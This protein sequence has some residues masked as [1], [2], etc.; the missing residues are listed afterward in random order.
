MEKLPSSAAAGSTTWETIKIDFLRTG[1]AGRALTL[2]SDLVD[3]TVLDAWR[4]YLAPKTASGLALLAVGGYG[5]RQLFPYS[6]VD[7]LLLFDSERALH[8]SKSLLA[9]FLQSLWD[10]GLRLSQSVRTIEECTELH[11]SNVELNVSLLDLRFLAGDAQFSGKLYERLP[12]FVHAQRQALVRNMARL[13]RERHAKYGDTFYHLEPNIKEAPGGLRD[14]QLLCWLTQIRGSDAKHI[15]PSAQPADL[16]AARR[17]FFHLRCHL[18]Y[19]Y[20]RD[21]NFL[22][23]D[24]QEWLAEIAGQTPE[25][26]MREYFLHARDFY[27]SAE[28]LLEETETQ[29]PSLFSNFRDWRSRLSNSEFAVHR[30]RVFFKSPQLLERDPTLALRLFEFAARH[31]LRLSPDTE[32]RLAAARGVLSYYYSKPHPIWLEF[33][34]LLSLPYAEV[35]L[36]EM[37]DTG[38]LTLLF[39]EFSG[40]ECLVVRDFYH[41]Y[42]VDE[43]TLVT[44]QSINDLRR[45]KESDPNFAARKPYAT[46][47]S[48][49]EEPALLLFALLFHDTGKAG[50][51]EHHS[52]ASLVLANQAMERIHVP[53]PDREAVRFLI[54]NHLDMS[55]TL[56]GRD[57]GDAAVVEAFAHRV[58]TVERLKALTLLTYADISGVNP[59]AMTPWRATQ[60]FSLY[61][62]TYHELTR[63]LDAER[64]SAR[65]QD[66]PQKAAFLSGFPTRYLRTHSEAEIEGHFTMSR[67]LA[68][69]GFATQMTRTGGGWRLTVLAKDRP[70]LFAS[71]AGTLSAFG[72]NILKAEAFANRGGDILDT[73]VFADPLRNL[74]LNPSEVDRLKIMLERVI[75]GWFD[76]RDLLRNRP[77]PTP[78]SRGAEVEPLV[79][80]DSEASNSATLIQ[81]TAADRPGLLYDLASRMSAAGCNIEVV[82]IDTEAHKAIDVFYVTS[83]QAKLTPRLQDKLREDLL[84]VCRGH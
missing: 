84:G 78:P 2:R 30:E 39:P 72:L 22:T 59:S 53:E 56:H 54:A 33:R 31:S 42:T 45:L 67:R 18:H 20:D 68:E 1:D 62:I 32:Q 82:L 64:I 63:E 43:H 35:A 34:N 26:W 38:F 13:T 15:A 47:L 21:S 28:R 55:A 23:F 9:P 25:K 83:G 10:S 4:E 36:R 73:F 76:V 27:R 5:R 80:F 8:S 24:A 61:R 50:D 51:G 29:S 71:I 79:T 57:I 66:S 16:E 46:L 77:A 49:L 58:G 7:L 44:I 70:N 52:D 19:S 40:V 6:D 3:R 11:D 12:R 81:I 17:F 48:E 65:P 41:R 60:L 69:S 14:F 75:G 74:D 37:H